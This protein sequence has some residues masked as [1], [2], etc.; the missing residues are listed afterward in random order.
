M[1]F[2]FRF[3]PFRVFGAGHPANHL[4][5]E[6]PHPEADSKPFSRRLGAENVSHLIAQDFVRE[7]AAGP[8]RL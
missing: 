4:H 6:R 8:E 7:R 2:Q 1:A 5:G 3:A